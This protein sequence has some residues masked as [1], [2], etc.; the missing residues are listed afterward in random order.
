MLSL[1]KFTLQA[2][3]IVV[4]APQHRRKPNHFATPRNEMVSTT[5]LNRTL[6]SVKTTHRI[7]SPP[8]HF[9]NTPPTI[10]KVCPS[11]GFV[12][13]FSALPHRVARAAAFVSGYFRPKDRGLTIR[14][15]NL[16]SFA[17]SRE[18]LE[19]SR[20]V[21][22][23]TARVLKASSHLYDFRPDECRP[24]SPQKADHTL[25]KVKDSAR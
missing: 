23:E 16:W 24:P 2:L 19:K 11:A 13:F 10:Y 25:I 20:G 3:Q 12:C 5:A 21:F 4:R 9:G 6:S 18:L 1:A 17:K 22:S 15:Q 7:P 14:N 8:C